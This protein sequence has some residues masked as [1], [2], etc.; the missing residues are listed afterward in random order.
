MDLVAATS[1]GD[2]KRHVN[3]K[4]RNWHKRLHP[5][6]TVVQPP[7][8]QSED[9][10][11][12][13][14]IAEEWEQTIVWPSSKKPPQEAQQS[15]RMTNDG[16]S[17]LRFMC[18][19]CKDNLEY[20]P[21]DLM[22]HFEEK[23]RGSLPVFPCHVCNFSTHEFSHL[24]VHLLSHKD[25]FASCCICNDNVQRSWSEFSAHLATNHCPD[26]KYSCERCQKFSTGD[27]SVFLEH[28]YGHDLDLEAAD[29]FDGSLLK[30]DNQ[31]P[32]TQTLRC[33]Y[34]DFE[35]SQK[36]LIEKHVDAVHVCQNGNKRKRDLHPIAVK[37]NDKM[38]RMK[39]RLT[40]SAVRDMCWITQDCLS[41]PGTEFLDKYCHLSDPQTTLE[42]TQQFLMK[43]VAGETD[44][45]KWTKALKTVLSNVP[46]D[47]NLH[48]KLE[49]GIVLN[50]SDL[51]VLKVKN[52]ITV[53]QNGATYSKMLEMMTSTDKETVSVESASG[54]AHCAVS[55]NGCATDLK[56]QTPCPQAENGLFT[57]VLVSV[58]NEPSQCAQMQE[59]IENRNLK[60]D[61][62]V[63]EHKKLEG[64]MHADG[65]HIS[66]NLMLTK[67]SEDMTPV[68]RA[69]P[70]RQ[71][72][73]HRRKRKRR[74]RKV[75]KRLEGQA[76]KIVLK[77]NPV[78]G[79]Q[80]V[81]QSSFSASGDDAIG[82]VNPHTAMEGTVHTLR[83]VQLTEVHQRNIKRG[84]T[85][86]PLEAI[87][88]IP[89]PEPEQDFAMVCSVK[90]VEP[91]NMTGNELDFPLGEVQV[92]AG[93]SQ[94][95]LETEVDGSRSVGQI[96]P[97]DA[98]ATE[99]EMPHENTQL[100][101]P[102]GGADC[103][104]MESK[105]TGVT[106]HSSGKSSPVSQTALP[107]QG[108]MAS[109]QT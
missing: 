54:D 87:T 50:P 90:P 46:K 7:A 21:K 25:T 31:I 53:G 13:K 14:K 86:D 81:S 45:Q 38:P 47:M 83:N 33:Q 104:V 44:D 5:R 60:T 2:N 100:Q 89:E 76:L 96:N 77:K 28:I 107:P 34:C 48:P 36:I 56:D 109:A 95:F 92:D 70:R 74:F 51:A 9:K 73:N 84:S 98:S 61:Q 68:H 39:P 69:I 30:K 41:L 3:K 79:K 103:H 19:Q 26:G 66:A 91:K 23:H 40:R 1:T 27:V 42:E 65:I 18:S 72:Q 43:S 11:G 94:L 82:L 64:S 57:D 63:E 106:L 99:V 15:R 35:A 12:P 105:K 78:K 93:K 49:N 4:N 10:H 101:K 6:K 80:W 37:P 58:Q 108:K 32:T 102:S 75:D 17:S 52:K 97:G 85:K 62:E 67:E 22:R 16:E 20:A 8:M 29:G 71:G 55:H 88:S 24:Q 59:N